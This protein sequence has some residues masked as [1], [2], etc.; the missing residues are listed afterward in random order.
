M[1]PTKVRT[2]LNWITLFGISNKEW[3]FIK[4]D[5]LYDKYKCVENSLSKLFSKPYNFIFI[6]IDKSKIYYN[7]DLISNKN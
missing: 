5:H 2:N 1:L 4:N 6:N 3:S 7:F